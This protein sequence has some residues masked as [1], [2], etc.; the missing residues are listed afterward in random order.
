MTDAPDAPEPTTFHQQA[1]IGQS[2]EEGT[3]HI[4]GT[5][6]TVR[7]PALPPN[8]PFGDV[9]LPDEEPLGEDVNALPALGGQSTKGNPE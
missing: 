7:Y 5:A 8:N 4:S 9:R 2:L 3:S 6:P 1:Q